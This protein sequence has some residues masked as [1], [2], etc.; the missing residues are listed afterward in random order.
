[1]KKISLIQLKNKMKKEEIAK[2]EEL[3]NIMGGT[4]GFYPCD[5]DASDDDYHGEVKC[6]YRREG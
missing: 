5:C 3:K 6:A 2:K 4:H 1:M